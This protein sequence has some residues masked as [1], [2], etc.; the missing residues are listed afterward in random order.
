MARQRSH[1]VAVLIFDNVSVF[2]MAVPCEVW[3]VD[4]VAMGVPR[5]E[6]RVCSVDPQPLGTSMGFTITT[7]HGIEALRWADTVVLPSCPKPL[8]RA[9]VP[10]EVVSALRRAHARGARL[11]SVCSGSFVLAAAGLLDGSRATTHWMWADE[12]RRLHPQVDLDPSVL[13]VGDGQVFTSAGTAAGIDLCLHLARLDWGAE[14]ANTIARRMVV[15]PHR[16]GGQAQFVL[17]PVLVEASD[18]DLTATLDWAAAHLDRDLSVEELARRA[19]MTPRT[20]ARRFKQATG[21][22]PLQWV[23]H[24][25][26]GLAQRLLEMTEVPIEI[27]AQ[28]SGFGTSATL[29]Q[30]FGRIVGTNPLAYRQAFSR[31]S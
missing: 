30:H 14:V 2:E 9:D 23:L 27:V 28:R 12:F 19:A 3:G 15:P 7:P 20:F 1:R 6:V 24:Q 21:T 5:S 11:A 10:A 13:Y 4:R 17:A 25:R 18:S 22:T 8:G 26:V 16:D 31:A 29:R